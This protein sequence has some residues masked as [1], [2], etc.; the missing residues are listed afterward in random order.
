MKSENRDF[1]TVITEL[2][3]T[4]IKGVTPSSYPCKP[5]TSQLTLFRLVIFIFGCLLASGCH[6]DAKPFFF[7]FSSFFRL[8]R[9][10]LFNFILLL[11]YK[12]WGNKSTGEKKN[13]FQQPCDFSS[14]F[15]R[16]KSIKILIRD[17][18]LK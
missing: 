13:L 3:K 8:F 16:G 2:I 6:L 11:L 10:T 7:Y 17:R 18:N 15:N 12:K 4:D 14:L 5:N 9:S 1:L